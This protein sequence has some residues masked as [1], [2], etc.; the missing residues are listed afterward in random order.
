MHKYNFEPTKGGPYFRVN[1]P[2]QKGLPVSEKFKAALGGRVTQERVLVKKESAE[3]G[4][5]NGE[6]TAEDSQND[7]L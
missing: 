3:P 4:A 6:V 2:K 5:K 7:T 1:R